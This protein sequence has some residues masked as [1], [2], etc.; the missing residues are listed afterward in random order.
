MANGDWVDEGYGADGYLL[1]RHSSSDVSSYPAVP[2]SGVSYTGSSYYHGGSSN[3]KFLEDPTGTYR[4]NA[5]RFSGAGVTFTFNGSYTGTVRVYGS[6]HDSVGRRSL[7][8]IE[9]LRSGE[10]AREYVHSRYWPGHNE[11]FSDSYADGLPCEGEIDVSSGDQLIITARTVSSSSLLHGVF[12]SQKSLDAVTAIHDGDG[13]GNW[14]DKGW[15]G[16]GVVLLHGRT[17]AAGGHLA[18]LHSVPATLAYS[19]SGFSQQLADAVSDLGGPV[20]K[21]RTFRFRSYLAGATPSVTATF[22]GAYNNTVR[23]LCYSGGSSVGAAT[24]NI[25]VNGT[26]VKTQALTQQEIRD[27]VIIEHELDVVDTDVVVFES[28]ADESSTVISALFFGEGGGG[29][30]DP[31]DGY[32]LELHQRDPFFEGAV[33]AANSAESAGRGE[34]RLNNLARP[35]SKIK[36]HKIRVTG[37]YIQTASSYAASVDVGIND[38]AALPGHGDAFVNVADWTA[39]EKVFVVH[40]DVHTADKTVRLFNIE[41]V[42]IIRVDVDVDSIPWP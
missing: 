37:S 13:V 36:V 10:T 11:G 38:G 5:G 20:D 2:V 26:T 22:S 32:A 34:I 18:D 24:A 29:D 12:F 42:R 3:T 28:V 30:P 41:N 25:K 19:G 8:I 31:G 40:D 7:C 27:G 39:F 16:D 9:I 6:D 23:M 4:R 21:T 33:G 1:I 15:G 35:D 17:S 14:V